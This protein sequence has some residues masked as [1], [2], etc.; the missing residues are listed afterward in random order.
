MTTIHVPNAD[1]MEKVGRWLGQKLRAGDVVV[2]N[3]P[4][5]AGKTTLTRGIGEALG[6][7]SPV[8]SPTFIV[9]REHARLDRRQPPFVHVDAYRI[10]SGAEMHDLDIAWEDSISVIEWG[11]HHVEAVASQWLDLDLI[12]PGMDQVQ[13]GGEF[14]PPEDRIVVFSAHSASGVPDAHLTEL[15]EAAHD[16]LD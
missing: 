15:V 8:Q 11:R 10:P 4:L 5:G 16:C 3:G 2:L 14:V 13:D 6:L 1:A 9:A 12:V 7:T